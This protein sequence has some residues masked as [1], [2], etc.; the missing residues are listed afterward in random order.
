MAL[1]VPTRLL[2]GLVVVAQA[3][4]LAWMALDREWILRTGQVVFLRT[5]PID[6]RDPFRGDFV[7]LDYDINTVPLEDG[8]PST[9]DEQRKRRRH[10]VVYTRLTPAGDGVFEALGATRRRPADGVVIRGRTDDGWRF[11]DT[12]GR[13]V[14]VRYGIE[15]LFVEQGRGL[16]IERRRGTRDSVQVPMEVEVAI[17]RSG[18]AVV[19]GYRW[20]PLGVKLEIVRPAARLA[21]PQEGVAVAGPTGPLSPSVRVTLVNVSEAAVAIADTDR[22]CAFRLVPVTWSRVSST[23]AT[24]CGGGFSEAPRV[25]T[26]A[27]GESYGLEADLSSPRWH[28]VHEGQAVEVGALTEPAQFRI[29][30]RAP[31]SAAPVPGVWR[32]RLRTARFT[33]AGLID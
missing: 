19:R 10:E 14:T 32:G 13:P 9:P 30:Y 4:V 15:Q 2:T 7:R 21:L 16:A 26:L 25:V 22:H 3:L 28:V 31:D 20:S 29:E 17:G 12:A 1:P 6:P 11:T 18:T 8:V 24:D 23:P 5:A 27:P 33:G